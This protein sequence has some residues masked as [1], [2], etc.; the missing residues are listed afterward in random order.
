MVIDFINKTLKN[1]IGKSISDT[2]EVTSYALNDLEN[3]KVASI[4]VRNIIT[5]SQSDFDALEVKDAET[6]YIIQ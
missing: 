6:L 2:Q 1:S 5:I 4:N 3:R